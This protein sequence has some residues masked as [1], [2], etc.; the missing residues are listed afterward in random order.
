MMWTAKTPDGMLYWLDD[1]DD[2]ISGSPLVTL[3]LRACAESGIMLAYPAA[4][5]VIDLKD[6]SEVRTALEA[7]YET[8]TFSDNAPEPKDFFGPTDSET[9]N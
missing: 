2:P 1:V 5:V 7:L 9:L 4:P 8:A 3:K 6:G